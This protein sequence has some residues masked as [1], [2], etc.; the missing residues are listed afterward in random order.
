MA[1]KKGVWENGVWKQWMR[2]DETFKDFDDIY[3]SIQTHI[4]I[5]L[6]SK[7]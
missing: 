2:G 3:Q 1:F 4:Q 5:L 7:D 6:E